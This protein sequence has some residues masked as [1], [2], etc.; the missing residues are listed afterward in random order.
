MADLRW[1]SMGGTLVDGNGDLA[2]TLSPLE[3]LGTMMATRIK[4]AIN[5]WKS[6]PG[7]GAG[8]DRY[9]GNPTGITRDTELSLQR[10]VTAARPGAF[11]LAQHNFPRAGAEAPAQ[12][13]RP[14]SSAGRSTESGPG[15][16]AYI[17][18]RRG[19]RSRWAG[20]RGPRD[21]SGGRRGVKGRDQRLGS[22]GGQ[23]PA[24]RES[25]EEQYRGN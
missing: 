9:R 4:G 24:G 2:V 8:L 18:G 1:Q 17:P 22:P 16:A 15:A 25:E 14:C 12:A 5:A 3:E 23:D 7:I 10:A 11:P 6:Y 20:Q 13:A 19:C 21:V